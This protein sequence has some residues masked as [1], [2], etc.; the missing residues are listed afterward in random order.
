MGPRADY[1]SSDDDEDDSFGDDDQAATV[2][3]CPMSP[4]R[5][6]SMLPPLSSVQ[7][8]PASTRL[9]IADANAM[10]DMLSGYSR[11][12]FFDDHCSRHSLLAPLP[13]VSSAAYLYTTFDDIASQDPPATLPKSEPHPSI[14]SIVRHDGSLHALS[15]AFVSVQDSGDPIHVPVDSS[16]IQQESMSIS[17]TL[18]H[19]QLKIGSSDSDSLLEGIFDSGAGINIRSCYY[20]EAIMK[21]NPH[22][23]AG[24][25]RFEDSNTPPIGFWWYR[26]QRHHASRN[27][28]DCVQDVLPV[29]WQLMST[30]DLSCR[31]LFGSYYFWHSFTEEGTSDLRA[32][33]RF[34][35]QKP[36]WYLIPCVIQYI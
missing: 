7:A 20:H 8:S 9:A 29:Q 17:N 22:M 23:V 2:V 36:L 5:P 34:S 15:T 6:P 10:Q 33:P 25:H 24:I 32:P 19:I 3:Q 31:R 16:Q 35:H 21:K 12:T 27:S 26:R 28:S 13:Q 11:W 1:D 14:C 4:V 18:P 30:E